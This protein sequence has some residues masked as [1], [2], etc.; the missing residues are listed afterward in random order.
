[1]VLADPFAELAVGATRSD[2]AVVL[3][4]RL[5]ASTIGW[6]YRPAGGGWSYN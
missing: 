2:G 4:H 1:M 6:D 5:P 3:I